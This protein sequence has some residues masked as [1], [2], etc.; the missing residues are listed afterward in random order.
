MAYQLR[1]SY[2]PLGGKTVKKLI[3]LFLVLLLLSGCASTPEYVQKKI[4]VERTPYDMPHS[5]STWAT[6]YYPNNDYSDLLAFSQ[7]INATGTIYEEIMRALLSGTS[8]GYV[9][10]FP[11]GVSCRNIMLVQDI[12]YIDMSWQFNQMEDN[13][14]F[15]CVS[16][17]ATTFTKLSEISFVNITVEGK[18]ITLPGMPKHPIMLLSSY[19]GTISSLVSRYSKHTTSEKTLE[20]FYGAIYVAD[21]TGKY[22]LPKAVNVTLRDNDYGA[23]LTSVLLA[24]STAIFPNGFMLSGTPAFDGKNEAVY[25]NLICPNNWSYAED[26]LGP[27]ALICTLNSLYSDANTLKLT[28]TDSQGN[29]KISISEKTADYFNKIKSTVEVLTPDVAGT[30]LMRTN[31]LVSTMPGSGDLKSFI[32]EY[33]YTVNPTFRNTGVVNSIVISNDTA[34][35]DLSAEYFQYYEKNITSSANE[36]AV[37]YSLIYVACT[38]TGTSKALLLEDG[39]K[40]S[41]LAGYIKTDAPLLNLPSEY[42]DSI[43]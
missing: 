8:E 22:I 3:S 31:M 38:Y 27:N 26:W 10:P 37:I 23:L 25:V 35:I 20:T 15:A 11:K 2:A 30:G 36:Y 7:P 13:I 42:V 28:V 12:L 33:L 18:Q 43:I 1:K 40:R 6:L 29:E 9:S 21:E 34:I 24:E 5:Q 4:P 32:N 14:F 19:T 39:Q 41:T 17:L 16:V